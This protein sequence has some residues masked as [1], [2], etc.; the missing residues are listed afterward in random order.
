MAFPHP[1][2]ERGKRSQSGTEPVAQGSRYRLSGSGEREVILF[3][4][5]PGRQSAR[6]SL[7]T[8]ARTLAGRCSGT[9]VAFVLALSAISLVPARA[10]NIQNLDL[11]KAAQVWFA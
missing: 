5:T 11:G 3:G 4:R 9:T 8:Y 7:R 2:G 10:A 6:V 1:C